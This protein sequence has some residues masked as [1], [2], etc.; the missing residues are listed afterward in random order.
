M[1][2]IERFFHICGRI[3]VIKAWASVVGQD[4][5][6]VNKCKRLMSDDDEDTIILLKVLFIRSQD[7]G[8]LQLDQMLLD[9]SNIESG[10]HVGTKRKVNSQFNLTRSNLIEATT[11]TTWRRLYNWIEL[12]IMKHKRIMIAS[13]GITSSI[14][15]S[16]MFIVSENVFNIMMMSLIRHQVS[17]RRKFRDASSSWVIISNWWWITF[18]FH[19]NIN[20][21]IVSSIEVILLFHNILI[22]E[23]ISHAICA[24]PS[25]FKWE[26][27]AEINQLWLLSLS[28]WSTCCTDHWNTALNSFHFQD[29]WSVAFG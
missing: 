26:K 6:T 2:D 12:I 17:L 14:N 28:L 8:N 1:T 27:V 4:H 15:R 21:W 22:W 9:N 18:T 19:S 10:G 24:K 13:I 11:I 29:E 16:L 3:I 23:L 5:G 7:E 20:N 25:T